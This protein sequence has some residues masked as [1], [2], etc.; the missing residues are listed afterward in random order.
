[1]ENSTQF[2]LRD[3][4]R[5]WRDSLAASPAC[6]TDD[7]D[8]LES[9]L[10]DSV[11]TLQTTGLSLR[12][13]FWVA[14]SRLGTNDQLSCEFAKVN[15]AQIWSDR[16]LWMLMG[17]LLL[18]SI[19]TLADGLSNLAAILLHGIAGQDHLLGPVSLILSLGTS[20]GMLLL[21]WRSGRQRNGVVSCVVDWMKCHPVTAAVG[22]FLIVPINSAMTF[23]MFRFLPLPI[24]TSAAT[25]RSLDAILRTMIIF[26]VALGWLLVRTRP[27]AAIAQRL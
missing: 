14:K 16:V 15:A 8:Q 2:D 9:H 25:W 22:M 13:A 7:L 11:T 23:L 17:S 18:G 1:M 24:F 12:E 4:I 27:K 3:A 5:Q 20:T 6:R 26:P 10:R 19:N 21:V